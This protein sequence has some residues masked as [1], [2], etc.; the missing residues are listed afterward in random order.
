ME[1]N[2]SYVAIHRSCS[3]LECSAGWC[4]QHME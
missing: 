4:I 3:E 2:M 1:I